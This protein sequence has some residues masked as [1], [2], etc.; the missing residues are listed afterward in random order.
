MARKFYV[1]EEEDCTLCPPIK[2]L[3]D[4]CNGTGILSQRVD[5][6]EA[7]SLI[8]CAQVREDG[9]RINAYR[10]LPQPLFIQED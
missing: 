8:K 5:L 6:L 2:G 4:A 1:T 3:C 7:L 10:A 9:R